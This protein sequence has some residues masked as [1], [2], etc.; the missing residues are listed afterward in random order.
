MDLEKLLIQ[1]NRLITEY[2]QHKEGL[3]ELYW[4]CIDEIDQR[5]PQSLGLCFLRGDAVHIFLVSH[6][7]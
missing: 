1:M 4:L 3:E 2:P 6:A 5:L 7:K